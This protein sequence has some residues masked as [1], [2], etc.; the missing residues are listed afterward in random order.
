MSDVCRD[1][2]KLLEVYETRFGECHNKLRLTLDLLSI[3]YK[4]SFVFVSDGSL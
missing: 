2:L 3:S 1:I 4:L